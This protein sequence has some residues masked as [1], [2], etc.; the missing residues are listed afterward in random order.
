M[1]ISKTDFRTPFGKLLRLPLKLIPYK[2]VLPIMQ[3]PLKGK[4]WIKGAYQW[5]LA[6]NL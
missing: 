6:S 4:K 5:L 1:N 3:G 2:T